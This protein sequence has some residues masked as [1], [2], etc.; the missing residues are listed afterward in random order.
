MAYQK[1]LCKIALRNL[2]K[3]LKEKYNYECE[4]SL[5]ELNIWFS[6]Q[7]PYPEIPIVKLVEENMVEDEAIMTHEIIELCKLKKMNIKITYD[8]FIKY[9]KKAELAHIKSLEIE[10]P[11]AKDMKWSKFIKLYI[12][13]I[14]A[15]LRNPYLSK[16]LKER[17]QK[18][19]K[20]YE[21]ALETL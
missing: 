4:T 20:Q 7:T 12:R 17:Y 2:L 15:Y 10:L 1:L 8:V 19:L 11:I 16:E 6:A 5:D 21:E 9:A 13:N 3:M 18:L 14:K